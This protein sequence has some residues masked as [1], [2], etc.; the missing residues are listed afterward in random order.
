MLS[1]VCPA[2]TAKVEKSA[3]VLVPSQEGQTWRWSR[4][5]KLPKTSNLW[6][7]VRQENS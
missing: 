1:D 6:R 5:A 4:L 7:Q 3:L 2:E